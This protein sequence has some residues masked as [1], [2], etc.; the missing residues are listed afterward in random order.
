MT[1]LVT[2]PSVSYPRN[3]FMRS[4]VRCV[5]RPLMRLFFRL[6]VNHLDQ[7]PPSG[8]VILAGN[9]SGVLEVALMAILPDRQV[10]FLGAGDIPL[11]PTFAW[12]ARSYGFIPVKRGS[13]DR[14]ALHTA[15]G[16]LRQGGVVGLFPEGGLWQ[17]GNMQARVGAAWLAQEAQAVVVPIGFQGMREALDQLRKGRRPELKVNV[18]EPVLPR[19]TICKTGRDRKAELSTIG[20]EILDQIRLL[21]GE[22]KSGFPL[23]QPLPA[24]IFQRGA[25]EGEGEFSVG[26]TAEEARAVGRFLG[27]PVLVDVF[28]R[29]LRLNIHPLCNAEKWF[30]AVELSQAC[31]HVLEYLQTN[32]GF[33]TYRF[34]IDEGLA[35]G[36]GIRQLKLVCDTVTDDRALFRVRVSVGNVSETDNV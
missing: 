32:P 5:G 20:Q 22:E 2:K 11:D 14:D 12:L 33:F 3:S 18:G 29:N 24:R 25:G 21:T 16:V 31:Q 8:P 30:S 35:V 28:L 36:S 1:A 6:V 10:E 26:W 15:L 19:Q 34:G 13:L 9:H 7:I 17:P 27:Q 4:A 23:A